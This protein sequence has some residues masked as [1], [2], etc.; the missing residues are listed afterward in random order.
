MTLTENLG[1]S[2]KTRVFEMV[3]FFW[4]PARCVPL[5]CG[6]TVMSEGVPPELMS[7]TWLIE[8]LRGVNIAQNVPLLL[9]RRYCILYDRGLI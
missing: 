4:G 8:V 6:E 5:R 3:V 1:I 2:S 7:F 9:L